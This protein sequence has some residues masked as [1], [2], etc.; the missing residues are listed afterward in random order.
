MN[1]RIELIDAN[2]LA[3]ALSVSV[4]TVR[5]WMCDGLIPFH[6]LSAKCTRYDLAEILEWLEQ[7]RV[8]AKVS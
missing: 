7:R 1:R 4:K 6:R 8:K 5:K 3:T 2:A